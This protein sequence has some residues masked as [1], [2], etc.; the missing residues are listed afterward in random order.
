MVVALDFAILGRSRRVVPPHVSQGRDRPWRSE[1]SESLQGNQ[2]IKENYGQD[3]NGDGRSPSKGIANNCAPR[4]FH[5]YSPSVSLG[6]H[7]SLI[8]TEN[9]GGDE[10]HLK[11]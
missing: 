7:L 1:A 2:P 3:R 5:M 10:A 6:E 11:V 8:S 4:F 9:C